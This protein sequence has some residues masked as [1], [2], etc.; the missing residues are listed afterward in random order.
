[1]ARKNVILTLVFFFLIVVG[2]F[3][4]YGINR[5]DIFFD[6]GDRYYSEKLNYMGVPFKNTSDIRA[7]NEGYSE[8]NDCPWGF[9]HRGIDFF[10]ENKSDVL[11]MAP[12]LVTEIE[13][14]EENPPNIYHVRIWVRF[15]RS[16]V[17]G[18]NFEPWTTIEENREKQISFFNVSVGDWI[19]KGDVI[20]KFLQFGDGAHI[21]FDIL[22]NNNYHCPKKYFSTEG[23]N[24]MMELIHY[25][26]PDWDLCYP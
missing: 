7:F 26:H 20:A 13:R 21:H 25:F 22:E 23:Y 5:I 4:L 24:Q 14:H 17:L 15:N 3:I 11:A 18:Y 12:G 1:M 2:S 9:E 19:Q 8:N 6:P 16:V 10:F